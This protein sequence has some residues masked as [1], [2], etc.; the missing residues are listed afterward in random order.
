[1]NKL[2]ALLIAATLSGCVTVPSG[3]PVKQLLGKLKVTKS[4]NGVACKI[5][6]TVENLNQHQLKPVLEWVIYDVD[7][8]TMTSGTTPYDLID[9]GK[10][11]QKMLTL[12]MG[13]CDRLGKLAVNSARMRGLDGIPIAGV[14]GMNAVW[15]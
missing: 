13:S 15:K 6:A 9:A 5:D 12:V 2:F 11:Q 3:A 4:T 7:G 14:E 8:N 1:M 10:N